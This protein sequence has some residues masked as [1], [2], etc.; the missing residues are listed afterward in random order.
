MA[1]AQSEIEREQ[2]EFDSV[3]EDGSARI[4]EAHSGLADDG[5]G[6]LETTSGPGRVRPWRRTSSRRRPRSTS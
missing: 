4:E 3:L 2:G 5:F 1:R 6:G